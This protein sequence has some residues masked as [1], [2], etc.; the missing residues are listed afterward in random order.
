MVEIIYQ[1]HGFPRPYQANLNDLL[2]EDSFKQVTPFTVLEK[3][4]AIRTKGNKAAHGANETVNT[5][6]NILREAHDLGCWFYLTFGGGSLS[7][8]PAY[9]PP[10]AEDTKSQIKREKKAA[11]QKLAEAETQM[12]ALLEELE[13]TRAKAASAQKTAA[14]LKAMADKSRKSANELE[15]DEETTRFRLID[16]MLADAGWNVGVNGSDTDEVHQ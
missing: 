16:S 1:I 7:D 11:L 6:L 3:F 4:N 9:Q 8:C 5:S 14:E 2:N 12:K 15:F 10:P 13:A